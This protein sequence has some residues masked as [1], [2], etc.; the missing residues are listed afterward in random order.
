MPKGPRGEEKDVLA[1]ENSDA[2]QE[3]LEDKSDK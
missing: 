1:E 2:A 3:L